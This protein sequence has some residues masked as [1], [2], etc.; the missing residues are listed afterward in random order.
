MY[1]KDYDNRNAEKEFNKNKFK[2]PDL[3]TKRLKL[4]NEETIVYLDTEKDFEKNW[5]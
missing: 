2:G 3:Y 1:K 4:P 5:N